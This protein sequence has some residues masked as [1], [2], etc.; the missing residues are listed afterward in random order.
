MAKDDALKVEREQIAAGAGL[1]IAEWSL[2]ET[3]LA[4]LFVSLLDRSSVPV[5][6]GLTMWADEEPERRILH[7]LINSVIG[8]AARID[9]VGAAMTEADVSDEIRFMWPSIASRLLKKYKSR[10]EVA[11][12]HISNVEM[13][14][15]KWVARLEPFATSVGSYS[16]K[17]YDRHE[18]D[19]KTETFRELRMALLWYRGE[20]EIERGREP[21]RHA[22]IPPLIQR[23][24]QSLESRNQADTQ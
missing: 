2:V 23:V 5:A 11:H 24:L 6:S 20:I 9:L 7:S 4:F 14:P 22:P 18:L 10:H 21:E 13:E 15:G 19:K 1:A 3:A 17:R 16:G 8:F 12:F